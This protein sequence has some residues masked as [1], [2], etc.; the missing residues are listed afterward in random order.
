[1][2]ASPTHVV[3]G[4]AGVVGRE[5]VRA[6]LARGL[7]TV[8]VS[9]TSAAP[10]GARSVAADLTRPA[11]ARR[12]LAGAGVAYLVLGLP[13]SARVWEEQ[14]PLVA[15]TVAEAALANGTHLVYLDNVYAYGR[16]DGPMTERTPIAPVT[17]KGRARAAALRELDAAAGRGLVRTI[18]RSAD[19]YGPGATTSAFSTFA[20][21]R[22][23]AGK[24]GI[25][26]FDADQP[27]SMTYTPDIGDALA[28][29][30]TDPAARGGVWHL[31]TAPA[32]TGREYVALA[33]GPGAPCRVMGL[34]TMRIGGLFRADAR[35]TVEMA[36]QY[37]APYVLDS[38][39]FTSTFGM[40]ATPYADGI[41]T[42]LVAARA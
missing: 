7:D 6:L 20:V 21:D 14:W 36:Y 22:V 10:A 23:A 26:L 13:Y 37:T 16:V 40:S 5:T 2:T 29:L 12:A 32:L 38:S 24:D 42:S 28:V 30:G 8:S 9:R 11:D 35:E 17:R 41:R 31:P 3:L 1:M 33:A 19:F 27:H 4:G 34:G 15:R 39:A 18:G 25:W